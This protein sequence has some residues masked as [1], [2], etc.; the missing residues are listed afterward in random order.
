MNKAHYPL[1]TFAL[2]R[3]V[4]SHQI[5]LTHYFETSKW[6]QGISEIAVEGA[7]NH[8]L[9]NVGIQDFF[10]TMHCLPQNLLEQ[11]K[12]AKF[13][14][15]IEERITTQNK[16]IEKYESLI[17]AII[18]QKKTAGISKGD[19]QKTELSNVLQER[20]ERI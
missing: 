1:Y 19:W 15:L 7:R 9:L 3:I 11:E 2:N 4:M 10:E 14:N 18:Y 6:H 5:F 20:I 12:I 8:G 13:L 17:Q 16:I